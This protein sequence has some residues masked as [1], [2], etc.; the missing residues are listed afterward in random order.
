MSW[1]PQCCC[2]R[3]LWGGHGVSVVMRGP[4]QRCWSILPATA[5]S[6]PS[7]DAS[8]WAGSDVPPE[9]EQNGT[10]ALFVGVVAYKSN[11]P[12]QAGRGN[13]ASVCGCD[14]ER[15]ALVLPGGRLSWRQ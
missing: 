4:R 11:Q 15:W 3:D 2:I 7:R 1:L 5:G 10:I 6:F 9:A 12:F 13:S 14:A 8:G